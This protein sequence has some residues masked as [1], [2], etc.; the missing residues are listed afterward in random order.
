MRARW[1]FR[2]AATL[3][4]FALLATTPTAAM[5]GPAPTWQ[6]K[7]ADGHLWAVAVDDRGRT[8]VTGELR[9]RLLLRAYG[10][11]SR[12]LWSRTW[13]PRPGH[14]VC[15][16]ETRATGF[17]IDVA[18]DGSI[19]VG[20][21]VGGHCEGGSWF[22][23]RTGPRGRTLWHREGS[24]WRRGR[25]SSAVSGLDANA[26]IVVVAGN[27]VGCC[28][29][30]SSEGWLRAWGSSGRPLW[31][32]AFEAPTVP[33]AYRDR[34]TD[35]SIGADG[36][37]YAIGW[38]DR[39]LVDQSSDPSDTDVFVQAL[40]STG[41]VAWTRV[42]GDRGHDSD[43][44]TAIAARGTRLVVGATIE[45]IGFAR[46]MAWIARLS[47]GGAVL[48]TRQWTR[49]WLNDLDVAPSGATY[50]V[51]DRRFR[52]VIRKVGVGGS[53]V[54]TTS[55]RP[56]VGRYIELPG[57]AA[58]RSGASATAWMEDGSLGLLLRFSS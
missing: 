55:L 44:G 4:A 6:R 41:W 34:A 50:V 8:F 13:R 48:R 18:P 19:Y 21:Q 49:E 54:W 7:V 24:G 17:A 10:P 51:T 20:G 26:R 35:V 25:D 14:A 2:A 52:S 15:D 38:V 42:F 56:T 46:R 36:R 16:S 37:I 43:W 31:T 12:L 45:R 28:D 9:Q 1:S 27:D 3:V 33:S 22:L 39:L 58:D 53:V 40:T 30:P 29:D 23:R 57:V 32:N 47:F 5:A 11:R